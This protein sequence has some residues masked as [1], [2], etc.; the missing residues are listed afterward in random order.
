MAPINI[1]G[2]PRRAADQSP[3]NFFFGTSVDDPSSDVPVSA[4]SS[5][6]GSDYGSADARVAGLYNS[7][8]GFAT[9]DGSGG[10]GSGNRFVG[11]L[12]M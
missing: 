2:M 4:P 5:A 3:S 11:N 9:T 8:G 12:G 7:R 1:P 6:G 10:G